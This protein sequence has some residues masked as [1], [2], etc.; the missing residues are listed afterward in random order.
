V[1][2]VTT[3]SPVVAVQVMV[4]LVVAV[5]P[6]GTVTVCELPP[7]TEQFGATPESSTAW[8]SAA[9]PLNVT[10]PFVPIV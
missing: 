9:S 4:K 2:V 5:P 8:L 3:K 6:E 10:R 1:L 7:F